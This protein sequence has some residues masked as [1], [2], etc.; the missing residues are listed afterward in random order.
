MYKVGG[1][2]PQKRDD[3]DYKMVRPLSSIKLLDSMDLRGP[4]MPPIQDQGELGSCTAHAAL[5]LVDYNLHKATGSF[6]IPSRLYEY[7]N[8][9]VLE[10]TIDEDS[11]ASI[12]D[13]IKAIAKWGSEPETMRSYDI[14]KFMEKPTD[15]EYTF[16]SNHQAII[17][18]SLDAGPLTLANIKSQI[19]LGNPVTF[20]T[21]VYDQIFRV[22]RGNPIIMM[23]SRN[24][25][26]VGGHAMV[27]V[28][29]SNNQRISGNQRGALLI[30][31]SWG[32]GW[33][34]DGYGWLPYGYVT[35]GIA[36]DFWVITRQEI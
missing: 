20:G 28:G 18:T 33:G 19:V 15:D 32:T 35:K 13:S 1:W 7:Y 26:S 17:Y 3:R 23:P 5:C 21:S 8:T 16:G 31:N 14:A 34:D 11:G 10:G 4:H 27:I 12:R 25:R 24:E 29:Y 6:M 9:R 22:Y 30:R 36:Q 2:K